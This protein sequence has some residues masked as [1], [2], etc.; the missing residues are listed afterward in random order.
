MLFTA[1]VY[2]LSFLNTFL[3]IVFYFLHSFLPVRISSPKNVFHLI[4]IVFIL[5]ICY[6]ISQ[7]V[8]LFAGYDKEC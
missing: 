7:E 8:V 3:H 1:I 6:D 5:T 2:I 4:P